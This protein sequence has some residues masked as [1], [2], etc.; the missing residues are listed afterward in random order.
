MIMRMNIFHQKKHLFIQRELSLVK[1]RCFT[2][3]DK[4]IEGS[5]V[6]GGNFPKQR[7]NF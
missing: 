7:I 6:G 5:I 4:L 2:E 1:A 3:N